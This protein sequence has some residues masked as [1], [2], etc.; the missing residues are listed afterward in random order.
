MNHF[1]MFIDAPLVKERKMG[2]SLFVV[3]GDQFARDINAATLEKE[4]EGYELMNS[5][6]IH[7]S[8][9]VMGS[10]AYGYTT[11]VLLTFKKK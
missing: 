6:P 3:N 9:Q 8:N 1:T 7:S 10:Y 5:I 11:G 4:K 2:V